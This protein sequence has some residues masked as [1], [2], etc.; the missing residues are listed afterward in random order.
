MTILLLRIHAVL[1]QKRTLRRTLR[2]ITEVGENDGG[3]ARHGEKM[4][5]FAGLRGGPPNEI[6]GPV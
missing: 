1:T 3:V 2:R 6:L 5:C 4:T